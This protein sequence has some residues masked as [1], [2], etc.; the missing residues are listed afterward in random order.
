MATFDCMRSILEWV[1][2]RR[3]A[4]GHLRAEVTVIGK[5]RRVVFWSSNYTDYMRWDQRH[6]GPMRKY[7]GVDVFIGEFQSGSVSDI[8]G[9]IGLYGGILE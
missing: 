4:A 2:L 6:L 3:C 5:V 1:A 7:E 9:L 8:N